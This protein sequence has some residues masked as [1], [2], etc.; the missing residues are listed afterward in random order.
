MATSRGSP[1]TS[2]D[3]AVLLTTA[4]ARSSLTVRAGNAR[5]HAWPATPQPYVMAAAGIR[6]EVSDPGYPAPIGA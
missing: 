3:V 1:L 2:T 5:V 4:V 6:R